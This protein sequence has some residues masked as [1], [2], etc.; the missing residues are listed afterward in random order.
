MAYSIGNNGIFTLEEFYNRGVIKFAPDVLVYIGGSLQATVIAPVASKN[1][2]LSFNDGITNV[3]ISNNVDP[4][5]SSTATIEV[6]TP[7]YG[8][9]SNYWTSYDTGGPEKIRLPVF[10]QMLEVKIYL[11]GRFLV[12]S[13][14]RYYSAFWGFITNVDE[15]YNGGLYKFTLTCVDM[16]RW[17]AYSSI[18]I[19]PI[20]ETNIAAGG[21]QTLTVFSTIFNRQ[22]PFN[23]I[24]TLTTN[25]GMHEF[26]TP[27]WVAQK[28]SLS[29]NYP[30][31]L[32]RKATDGIMKYWANRFAGIGN[33]LKMYGIS[34]RR[35]N[36]NGVVTEEPTKVVTKTGGKSGVLQALGSKEKLS[37]FIDD[38]YLANFQIFAD[39]DNM[40]S[41]E[42]SEYTTKLEIA[43][44]VKTRCNYEFF[45][46][47]NGNFI[48]K[49][50]FYNMNVK[51]LIPYSIPP[52]EII[53]YSFAQDTEGLVTVLNLTTPMHTN[54]K[55]TT[56][57]LGQGFHMD[58]D[59]AKRYGIRYRTQMIE[60][61]VN[62]SMAR[63]LALGHMSQ[64][65][66]KT[67]VGHVT[68]P[69]RPE[70]KLGYP[71]YVEHRDSFHYVKSVNHSFDYGGSATTTLSL[72][73]ERQQVPTQ[74]TVTLSRNATK[75][76]TN[77]HGIEVTGQTTNRNLI[78]KLADPKVKVV[79]KPTQDK[80][81][82][83]EKE[84]DA[85]TP[86][87][88][89]KV[90]P[91]TKAVN[92]KDPPKMS[93]KTQ[94]ELLATTLLG[95]KIISNQEGRY[96]V[97]S[98]PT[99]LSTTVSEVPYTDADGYR[100]I[101]SFPYGRNIDPVVV[102]SDYG[103]GTNIF[104][105]V[106]IAT[107]ARPVYQNE[108]VAMKSLFFE[109]R[110][111]CTPVYLEDSKFENLGDFVDVLKTD[112]Q[113]TKIDDV[114]TANQKE[115]AQ[116]TTQDYAKI[117]NEKPNDYVSAKTASEA[118]TLADVQQQIPRA[119]NLASGL[120]SPEIVNIIVGLK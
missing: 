21:G 32:F 20:P 39:Y 61:V 22:N 72:E 107:M 46:D 103:A 4:P 15:N 36:K 34:G 58:I 31:G 91:P 113:P 62:P 110:E 26:V 69:C 119:M 80:T 88:S 101:G 76:K 7:I 51:G 118:A 70:V 43:T 54:L 11:K 35:V 82:K 63:T 77:P 17:W 75:T 84:S 64:I 78:Y 120:T 111:G 92:S 100:V 97:V 66:A 59:L 106:Y 47:Q 13:K 74:A 71:I 24:Y 52:N 108:S 56:Y 5:G 98:D 29:E 117:V 104:K 9:N 94:E 109:D 25:M 6:V 40:G 115:Q 44:E 116:K 14:P 33:L 85:K 10:V 114:K 81:G 55:T 49:P 95:S 38:K 86:D 67:I 45:Q 96:V 112:E 41:F 16:L 102:A 65:N 79:N 19:H 60:Y 30:V 12:D 8:P 48:F 3:S 23:I 1:N 99:I 27:S 42:N 87:K 73:I 93:Q 18:N 90:T 28:T 83:K 57:D 68:I 89:V 105:D 2:S 50:P 53:N 37:Y